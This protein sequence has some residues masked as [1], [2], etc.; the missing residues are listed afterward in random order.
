VQVV[1]RKMKKLGIEVHLEAKAK[2]DDGHAVTIE[3]KDGKQL[4]LAADRV[5]VT[6][7]RRPNSDGLGLEKAGVALDPKGFIRVDSRLRTNVEGIYA[8]GD[9][10]GQPMLAHKATKE[11]EICAEVIAGHAAVMDVRAI[12]AVIFT[13]PEIATV[14]L[15][16]P[17]ARAQGRDVLVGKF[18]MAA[19]GRALALGEPDGFVK[20]VVDRE[21][22]Q[23]LG[24]HVV[25]ASASDVISE[26]ALALEMGAMA[27]DL[28]LTIHPHPTMPEAIMEAAKA[29]LGEAVHIVNR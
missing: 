18:P 19:L 12:A 3:T 15:G 27:E 6:V 17:E 29:A 21:S 26:G 22:K 1:A 24:L 7:G 2:G 20:V 28:G 11:G 4:K 13:D 9:V 5:L 25:G 16:E 8:I 14:G 10:A 23:L